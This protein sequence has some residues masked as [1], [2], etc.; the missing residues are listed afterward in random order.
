M[1]DDDPEAIQIPKTKQE[2]QLRELKGRE[3]M[4]KMRIEK[5]MQ[6]TRA[7][8]PNATLPPPGAAP[9]SAGS[10]GFYPKME[11]L[12]KKRGFSNFE[13]MILLLLVGNIM[14]HDVLIAANGKYVMRG[15]AQRE[16]TVGYLLYVLC[17]TLQ[18]RVSRRK[19]FYKSAKLLRDGLITVNTKAYGASEL[20][21]CTVDI[22]R[23]MVDSLMGLETEFSE[24]VE[25]SLLY[26][27]TVP[28][29]NV[30]LPK[31]HKETILTTITNYDAFQRC[32]KRV[33]LEDVVSYGSGLV[34]LFYG[35]SGTGKTMLANAIAQHMKK[36]VLVV[37][38]TQIKTAGRP[39]LLKYVFREAKLNDAV[40]FF[41]ECDSFFETREA[42]PILPALLQELEKYNG[43]MILATNKAYA[44]DEAMNRR[45]T[46]AIEFAN[47]DHH[48]R[49][50][51]WRKHIPSSLRV[52]DNVD[53]AALATDYELSGG[54]IKN[55]LLTA[56]SHA[57][58][59]EEGNEDP[60]LKMEDFTHGAKTQL[61]SFFNKDLAQPDQVIPKKSLDDCIFEKP[62]REK[63]LEV[64]A[65][66]KGRRHVQSMWGFGDSD[67]AE[68]NSTI[69]L[70]GPSGVGKSLAAE[71]IGYECGHSLRVLNLQTLKAG[72]L[73]KTFT[74]VMKAGSILVIDEAQCLLRGSDDTDELVN[75]F[76]YY[77]RKC[78]RPVILIAR[79]ETER[80]VDLS[81]SKLKV[82]L[83]IRFTPPQQDLREKL[84][85]AAFPKSTPIH[86]DVDLAEFAKKH[87]TPGAIKNVVFIASCKASMQ[88]PHSRTVTKEI[89]TAAAE[90][91][92]K[93]TTP[94][95]VDFYT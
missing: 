29:D 49:C 70:Y 81:Y 78:T 55:A 18:E 10:G 47:P 59:R 21:E 51:I 26:T 58:A 3:R 37:A 6:K 56:L 53:F 66:Y 89:L 45:V 90:E 34:L 93:L 88:P 15:D 57:V 79:T 94:Q 23:R 1:K 48:M 69:L 77:A 40:V 28:M 52:S 46:L 60:L 20:M 61:R 38:L 71:A 73:E 42:N 33:G 4:L 31:D 19:L 16:C 14:S 43:I 32:K 11:L 13:K 24:I 64:I 50:E 83:L 80:V 54:L 27:S 91:V 65:M 67:M 62:I 85:R 8:A 12:Q 36:K 63:V 72:M 82:N 25:G 2:A 87:M 92:I 68:M 35:P 9:S 84:W 44:M 75:L 39:E 7:A 74:E 30:V 5:R 22:D 76:S 41:D 17:E 95:R 86:A